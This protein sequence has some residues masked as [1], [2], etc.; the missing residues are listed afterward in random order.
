MRHGTA[1][2]YHSM[3]RLLSLF[4]LLCKFKDTN[5]DPE[6]KDMSVIDL[7]FKEFYKKMIK[8]AD[9]LPLFVWADR[10]GQVLGLINF[11]MIECANIVV[12]V[13]VRLINAHPAQMLWYICPLLTMKKNMENDSRQNIV[14]EVLDKYIE[15]DPV[16][17]KKNVELII[18]FLKLLTYLASVNVK[19]P[20]QVFQNILK[21]KSWVNNLKGLGLAMPILENFKPL[22]YDPKKFLYKSNLPAF[23]PSPSI[24][25][26]LSS[27]FYAFES[28]EK[29]KKIEF[30]DTNDKSL[31]FLIKHETHKDVRREHRAIDV[32]RYINRL[33]SKDPDCQRLGLRITTFCVHFIGDNSIIVEWVNK[34]IT[35]RESILKTMS[36]EEPANYEYFKYAPPNTYNSEGFKPEDWKRFQERLRPCFHTYFTNKFTN[37]NE[38][39]KARTLYTRSFAV[40]SMI[41]FLIGLGDR[42]T[43]NILIFDDTCEL[44]FIDFECIFNMGRTLSQPET[45][46]FRLTPEMQSALGLF[47]ED[48]EFIKTCAIVLNCLRSYKHLIISNFESF[49]T[50]PL[51]V[52]YTNPDISDNDIDPVNTLRIIQARLDGKNNYKSDNTYYNTLQQ[53]KALVKDASDSENLRKMWRG[54]APY[55]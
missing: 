7:K 11:N 19:K 21:K 17:L 55:H 26:Q 16:G 35:L 50:D 29:P 30:V 1:Y 51:S 49:I 15:K 9:Y 34:T 14:K 38:W 8:L 37:A 46:L 4:Y 23:N 10:I 5:F 3:P 24:I 2:Y 44:M 36:N 41:G 52:T 39:L 20:E 13:L 6:K 18:E 40:W 28:K 27:K 32:F 12:K 45:V 31:F 53:A 43:E 47:F 42:H 33:F 22:E 54:W 48:S 25:A